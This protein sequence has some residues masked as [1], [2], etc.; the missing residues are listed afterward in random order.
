MRRCRL[1]AAL[2]HLSHEVDSALSEKSD[3]DGRVIYDK[4]ERAL[5][6]LRWAAACHD[7]LAPTA[8][9]QAAVAYFPAL[10]VRKA[11]PAEIHA[12]LA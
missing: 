7:T 10:D 3:S 4:N 12:R 8:G 6:L 1:H 9:A 11:I 5:R 2:G